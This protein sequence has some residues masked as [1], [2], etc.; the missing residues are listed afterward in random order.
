LSGSRLPKK[1]AC[2]LD[3]IMQTWILS[4]YRG[5]CPHPT[6]REGVHSAL[7]SED[8]QASGFCEPFLSRCPETV[9][10]ID[11]RNAP[12]VL[13]NQDGFPPHPIMFRSPKHNFLSRS[14]SIH[15]CPNRHCSRIDVSWHPSIHI[16]KLHKDV[17][18]N[19]RCQKGE[20]VTDISLC[21]ILI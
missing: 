3:V 11:R 9:Y 5:H 16:Y 18:Q 15:T 21:E 12:E 8:Y 10:L 1:F 4:R 7:E 19:F 17:A 2:D 6:L 14:L 20:E 13:L